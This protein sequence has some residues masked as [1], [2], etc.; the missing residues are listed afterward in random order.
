MHILMNRFFINALLLLAAATLLPSC[1]NSNDDET[2]VYDDAAITAFSLTS[3]LRSV[4]TTSSTG[5]DS[6]YSVTDATV[7]NY[8]FRIDQA[9]GL[10]YNPDSLPYG[11]KPT[12]LLC[13][14]STLN[15]GVVYIEDALGTIQNLFYTTDSTDFTTP[16]NL[17]VKSTSGNVSRIYKVTVNIHQQ[18]AN[19]FSWTAATMP[20]EIAAL[21]HV[22]LM[23]LNNTVYLF[24]QSGTKTVV[25]TSPVSDG[26]T[27]NAVSTNLTLGADAYKNMALYGGK[28]YVLDGNTL[29]SSA[30][31]ATWNAVN[32]V[33]HVSRLLGASS[34]Q[35]YALGQV[36]GN[37]TILISEDAGMSW[38]P[39]S[40][41][42]AASSLPAEDISFSCISYPY[43][44]NAEYLM[45]SGN[46]SSA[47]YGSDSTA[48][49]WHKILTT[50]NGKQTGAWINHEFTY[51][52]HYPLYHQADLCV[53]PYGDSYLAV[54][55]TPQ[56][57][58]AAGAYKSIYL[59]RDYGLTWKDN[60]TYSV[61]ASVSAAI[62]FADSTNRLWFFSRSAKK[63][64]RGRLAKL[65]WTN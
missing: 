61:P 47:A 18:K 50:E 44:S 9:N 49:V 3:S 34:T 26:N 32:T 60:T 48:V 8:P 20:D 16:R 40:M 51:V 55:G 37:D 27:W 46:R 33:S 65:T 14:Y 22:K 25:Y 59:S 15:N 64:W 21:N 43:G 58:S 24:G 30:D 42:D 35:L 57:T 52:S 28:F 54:G 1:L 29:L 23:E 56:N 53:I 31:A 17:T 12:K 10:I 6:I 38:T 36:N 4:T 7:A 45:L 41:I 5:A 2:T 11:I 39:D 19:D 62:L 63:V 13:S